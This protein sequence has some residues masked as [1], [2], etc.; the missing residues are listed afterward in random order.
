MVYQI[1]TI[2]KEMSSLEEEILVGD[3]I[4]E[5]PILEL[6]EDGILVDGKGE[7]EDASN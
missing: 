1:I 3:T 4:E 6:G 5:A 7:E 2:E